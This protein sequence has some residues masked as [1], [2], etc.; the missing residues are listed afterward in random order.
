MIL[1]NDHLAGAWL[2]HAPFYLHRH[3]LGAEEKR[4][5]G[6][7][8]SDKKPMCNQYPRTVSCVLCPVLRYASCVLCPASCLNV[9]LAHLALPMNGLS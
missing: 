7:R 9:H 3:Q 4:A 8:I 2:L 5:C 6:V 1:S